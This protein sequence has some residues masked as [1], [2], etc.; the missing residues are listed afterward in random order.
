MKREQC[1]VISYRRPASIVSFVVFP[2][3]FSSRL[4]LVAAADSPIR[5]AKM[6]SATREMMYVGAAISKN[7]I[8]DIA[9][10]FFIKLLTCYIALYLFILPKSETE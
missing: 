2:L 3:A 7:L 10:M 4:I 5:T 1:L 8:E 6:G 9:R